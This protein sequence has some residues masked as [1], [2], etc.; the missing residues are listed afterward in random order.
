MKTL[1]EFIINFGNL[2][3]GLHRYDLEV[4]NDFFT[5]FEYSLIKQGRIDVLLI[6]EKQSESFLIFQFHF[7]GEIKLTCDRCLDEFDYPINMDERLIVKLEGKPTETD[8]DEIIFLSVDTYE[9]DVSPFIYEYLSIALPLKSSCDEIE[10]E[11]NSEMIS[12]MQK[13]NSQS[14]HKGEIDP[15]WEGLKNINKDK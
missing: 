10:K 3:A 12:I 9:L 11:C 13:V 4:N 1:K 15:R 5:H 6:V 14:E 2:K 8:N 7:E